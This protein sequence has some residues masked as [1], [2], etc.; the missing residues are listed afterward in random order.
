LFGGVACTQDGFVKNFAA[1]SVSFLTIYL[2]STNP[3]HEETIL[4]LLKDIPVQIIRLQRKDFVIKGMYDTIGIDRLAS[5]KAAM[6][7]N[8]APCLV[9]DA[10]TAMTYTAV[11]ETGDLMGGG[12]VPGLHM[13]FQ[14]MFAFTGKLP[15]ILPKEV[16]YLVEEAKYNKTPIQRFAKDTR[17]AMIGGCLYELSAG[18]CSIINGWLTKLDSDTAALESKKPTVLF[19]GGDGL[20]CADLMGQ[21]RSCILEEPSQCELNTNDVLFEYN[22]HLIQQG[23]QMLLVEKFNGLQPDALRDALLG[24]R[25]CKHFAGYGDKDGDSY[26][27]GTIIMIEEGAPGQVDDYY[28]TVYFDDCEREE[29][30]KVKELYGT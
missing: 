27:R 5:I 12:I 7:R 13:K 28:F 24:A 25:V 16:K 29:G 1:K 4:Y 8:K 3:E 19:S 6:Q 17:K 18:L 11:N 10:G 14:S 20:I 30:I 21:H 23:I 9:I 26:Y 15:D 2:I 22:R